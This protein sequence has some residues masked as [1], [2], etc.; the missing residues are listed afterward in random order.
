MVFISLC[1]DLFVFFGTEQLPDAD[2][3]FSTVKKPSF[4]DSNSSNADVDWD[5]LA[6]SKMTLDSE[7]CKDTHTVPPPLSY[8]PQSAALK[9]TL[10]DPHD[11]V[12][13]ERKRHVKDTDHTDVASD[14]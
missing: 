4:F 2:S 13:S 11:T 10:G 5:K 8:E 6:K 3:L 1:V 7:V 12:L 14:G 9:P